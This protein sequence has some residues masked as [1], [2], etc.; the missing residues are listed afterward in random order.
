MEKFKYSSPHAAPSKFRMRG[1]KHA[2]GAH[3]GFGRRPPADARSEVSFREV[4]DLGLLHYG[5][6]SIL[7]YHKLQFG[8]KILSTLRL[9]FVNLKIA[10]HYCAT[11]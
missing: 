8:L 9:S 5:N 7:K 2:E 10:K 11:K 4:G 6:A 3:L 1:T